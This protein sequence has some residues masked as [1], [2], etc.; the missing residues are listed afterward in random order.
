M[1]TFEQL[2]QKAKQ[3]PSRSLGANIGSEEWNA[4]NQKAQAAKEYAK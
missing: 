3:A 4:A 1:A 2:Q